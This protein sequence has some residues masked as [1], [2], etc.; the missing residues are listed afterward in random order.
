MERVMEEV[1]VQKLLEENKSITCAESC[2]GGLLCGRIVNVAGVSAVFPGGFVTYANE[3]KVR[4]LHVDEETLKEHGAVSAPTA[5]QMAK[6]AQMAMGTDC[7]IAVTGIAGPDGGTPQKPVGLV[8][9]ATLCGEEIVVTKNH[10][11]GNRRKVREQVVVAALE[12]MLQM[13]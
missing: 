10:F 7:A 11:Q 5:E 2:S 13:L 12:Q 1:L 4:L 3:A 6:G 8:Y 9:I